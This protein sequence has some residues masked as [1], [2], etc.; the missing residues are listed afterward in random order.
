M[1]TDRP[2]VKLR[3][4]V[5]FDETGLRAKHIQSLRIIIWAIAFGTVC[6]NVTGG[7]AMTGY[8]KSLGVS[9]FVFGLLFAASPAAG[10]VQIL[11]SFVL[12]R[13][14]KRKG[15]LIAA[16]LAARMVWLPFGLVPFFVP[17][18]APMVRIWMVSL[19]LV[20]SAVSNQFLSVSYNSLLADIIPLRIRG[21]Y[22]G[23][24]GRVSTIVGIAGGFLTAWLLDLFPGFNGYALVFALAALFGTFDI[25]L[26]FMVEFPA[27]PETK[28][29]ESIKVMLSEALRN[30]Q[31][32]G[33]AAFVT[34]WGF[35]LNLA[36]PFYLVY[37]RTVL[38]M[39]NTAITLIA[40]ILPNICSV[41][42]LAHWGRALDKQ[43]IK[44][45]MLRTA[46]WSGIAPLLWLV[47]SPGPLSFVLV[48]IAYVSTGLLVPAMEIS[49]QNAILSRSPERNRSMYI[50][51]YF[52][53][54][55]LVGNAFANAAG[56]WLLDNPLYS[57]ET[58]GVS[59]FGVALNRYNYLFLLSFVLRGLCAWVL[60]P[61]MIRPDQEAGLHSV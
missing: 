37:L 40:Q 3:G 7:I 19:F 13:S 59:L 18:S 53:V 60:L 23:A 4:P 14:R 31:F 30:K 9:D 27:M 39:S 49:S 24:R 8:L 5:L 43:G 38:V 52:C 36:V 56:G 17:L 10:V 6:F 35:S 21:S 26:F 11:A 34:I 61:R 58:M 22:L 50:A 28:D 15:I 32:L 51:I 25:T 2:A 29:K 48:I 57:L 42:I 46:R 12:E 47:V 54:T 41:L 55:T 1:E 20:I 45:V 44:H 33:L 16:G